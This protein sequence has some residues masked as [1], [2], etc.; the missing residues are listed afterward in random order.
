MKISENSSVRDSLSSS[1]V[2]LD[3]ELN[4]TFSSSESDN[5]ENTELLANMNPGKGHG[6]ITFVASIILLQRVDIDYCLSHL[7]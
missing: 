2:Q 5:G 7:Q 3:S 1:S 4:L 6:S